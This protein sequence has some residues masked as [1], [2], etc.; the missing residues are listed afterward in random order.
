MI[1]AAIP[2]ELAR[3]FLRGGTQQVA[4]NALNVAQVA[5]HGVDMYTSAEVTKRTG[6]RFNLAN[7]FFP[8]RKSALQLAKEANGGGDLTLKQQLAVIMAPRRYTSL[9][10][11]NKQAGAE[12]SPSTLR[13]IL[14]TIF[15]SSHSAVTMAK[16][17]K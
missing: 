6:G 1:T 13:K 8:N 2:H 11:A 7:I 14:A 12:P 4:H 17:A 3:R 15:P 9:E 16:T 5:R 10:I